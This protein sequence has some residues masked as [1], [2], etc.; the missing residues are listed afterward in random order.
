MHR[1]VSPS[2]FNRNDGATV[3]EPWLSTSHVG[4]QAAK[5]VYG[6]LE[7]YNHKNHRLR[8]FP[9]EGELRFTILNGR[10]V[11]AEFLAAMEAV[12]DSNEFDLIERTYSIPF[13]GCQLANGAFAD[14]GE[15]EQRIVR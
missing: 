4:P 11:D 5:D 9:P 7:V 1:Y 10:E 2:Q 8:A 13:E 6:A 14:D 12:R 3:K 15:R